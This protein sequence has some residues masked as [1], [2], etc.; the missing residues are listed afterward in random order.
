MDCQLPVRAHAA[1]D[2]I[3]LLKSHG[4]S[5]PVVQ[6]L[7]DLVAELR[8]VFDG[9]DVNVEYVDYLMRSYKSNPAE[10][11]KYAKFDRYK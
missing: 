1:L 4:G 6:T 8:K 11:K 7:D 2:N 9:D 5:L 3:E 10:W